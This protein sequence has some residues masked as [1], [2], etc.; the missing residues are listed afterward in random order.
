VF[1]IATNLLASGE[2]H[3]TGD[4][5]QTFRISGRI[6]PADAALSVVKSGASTVT[7]TSANQWTGSTRVLAG[8][9]ILR[10]GDSL[11]SGPLELSAGAVVRFEDLTPRAGLSTAL[12]LAEKSKLDLNGN[13]WVIDYTGES[14]LALIEAMVRDERITTTSQQPNQT[15]AFIEASALGRPEY[16]QRM[17]DDTAIII[18][19]ARQGDANL[20]GAVNAEDLERVNR[21]FNKN[22]GWTDG[23]FTRDGKVDFDDLLRVSQNYDAAGQFEAD[24]N[25]LRRQPR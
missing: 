22:G 4:G 10:E 16:A 6:A 18:T 19:V 3:L 20:D 7:L 25:R 23:D 2:L 1:D 13:A 11:G 14:P 21:F 17:L 15:I 9:I 24:W 5:N 8:T 12:T